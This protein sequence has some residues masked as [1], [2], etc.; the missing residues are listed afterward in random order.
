MVALPLLAGCFVVYV[1]NGPEA[2]AGCDGSDPVVEDDGPPLADLIEAIP[3]PDGQDQLHP[4][5]PV[6]LEFDRPIDDLEL[7][8][9]GP[10]GAI[11]GTLSSDTP[12]RWWTF[13]PWELLETSTVHALE[14][15]WRTY[16]DSQPQT[17]SWGFTTTDL[18]EPVD[19]DGLAGRV[20]LVDP[21]EATF[22]SPPD[23][24]A[25]IGLQLAGRPLVLGIDGVGPSDE[26]GLELL[27]GRLLWRS[28]C[29]P[30]GRYS[31]PT[32]LWWD[33]AR[34]WATPE[35]HPPSTVLS[36]GLVWD[37]EIDGW[38]APEGRSIE[39]LRMGALVDTAPADA[40]IE[41]GEPGAYCGVI[42][43]TVGDLCE[44]CP[45]GSSEFCL[46]VEF[47]EA[48]G[49]PLEEAAPEDWGLEATTFD[50]LV[51][52]LTAL[53]EDDPE[54][55]EPPADDCHLPAE[56]GGGQAAGVFALPGALLAIGH[57]RRRRA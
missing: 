45:D 57:R 3:D 52:E 30:T 27:W 19:P 51:E 34:A 38:I 47:V 21:G 53:A 13:R 28:T 44:P 9:S 54:C 2:P 33:G 15:A 36:E 11:D 20:F 55:G 39:G 48:R 8:L 56:C 37:L 14:V 31:E 4:W 40:L 46:G 43:V 24:G 29:W 6:E 35:D 16:P 25:I 10:A 18:G 1:P 32:A 42:E 22:V 26:D 5:R 7:L 12:G 23:V 50:G 41:D 17:R 49:L